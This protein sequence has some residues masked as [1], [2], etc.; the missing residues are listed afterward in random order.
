[1]T[2]PIVSPATSTDDRSRWRALYALLA[3]LKEPGTRAAF[4]RIDPESP[5]PAFY[6]V[7]GPLLDADGAPASGAFRDELERR[8]AAIAGTLAVGADCFGSE[9][10]GGA[11]A[12]AAVAEMRLLRL[13]KAHDEALYQAVR[14]AIHQLASRGQRFEP[15]EVATLILSDRNPQEEAVR[16]NIARQFYRHEGTRP[17]GKS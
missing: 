17:Q 6:R 1:M 15:R 16:R 11:L 12:A 7:I 13:L 5:P 4:R 2:E 9:R 8:W 14:T 3:A 10:L